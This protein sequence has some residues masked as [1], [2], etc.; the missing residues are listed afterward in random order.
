MS[1]I[2]RVIVAF[3]TFCVA[4]FAFANPPTISCGSYR[5]APP[6]TCNA[7]RQP[8]DTNGN[9]VGGIQQM[10]VVQQGGVITTGY[11]PNQWQQTL[12]QQA[13][14]APF[15]QPPQGYC[16]W[17]GRTENIAIGGALGAIVGAIAGDNRESARKGF[18]VGAAMGTFVPC[19]T[20]HQQQVAMQQSS[21]VQ[22]VVASQQV[23]QVQVGGP[24]CV[25]ST[26][27]RGGLTEAE[28]SQ[29]GGVYKNAQ[30]SNQQQVGL[31]NQPGCVSATVDGVKGCYLPQYL[32][33]LTRNN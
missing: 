24:V 5:V 10:N 28:C 3:A 2:S 33:T 7:F 26:R 20:L 4:G 18:L 31:L 8:Y 21:Q 12:A 1:K 17:G 6:E 29:L 14:R 19:D 16:S 15:G 32:Q 13:I 23:R 11:N 27:D 9:P 25:L 30:G 22:N